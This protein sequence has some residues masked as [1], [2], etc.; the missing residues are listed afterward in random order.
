MCKVRTLF[1]EITNS[2]RFLLDST[3]RHFFHQ[4]N[5]FFIKQTHTQ[6]NLSLEIF[7]SSSNNSLF[8]Q[9]DIFV[10]FRSKKLF[11]RKRSHNREHINAF[12]SDEPPKEKAKES[13]EKNIFVL[14]EESR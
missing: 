4:T 3:D 9:K 5:I 11:T 14:E 6:K 12:E 1:D 2:L 7:Q 8:F 10:S 13:F